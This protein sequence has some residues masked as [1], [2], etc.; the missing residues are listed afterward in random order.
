MES[1]RAPNAV[2]YHTVRSCPQ[3]FSIH[4][5]LRLMGTGGGRICQ[6]CWMVNVGIAH[7][8]S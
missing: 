7:P 6:W 1:Y 2:I 4:P 3:G 8:R 5:R